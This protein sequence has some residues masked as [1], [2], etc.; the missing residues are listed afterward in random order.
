MQKDSKE[1]LQITI[2]TFAINLSKK[3]NLLFQL[4]KFKEQRQCHPTP[5]KLLCKFADIFKD[6]KLTHCLKISL[7]LIENMQQKNHQRPSPIPISCNKPNRYSKPCVSEHQRFFRT[8]RGYRKNSVQSPRFT[9]EEPRK[10]RGEFAKECNV[11]GR[12]LVLIPTLVF[13]KENIESPLQE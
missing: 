8:G 12:A 9:D 3:S 5:T 10:K 4:D 6:R 11:S 1:Q 2:L 13:F 7:F